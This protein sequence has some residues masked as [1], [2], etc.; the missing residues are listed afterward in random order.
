MAVEKIN[1]MDMDLGVATICLKTTLTLY[2]IGYLITGGF[3]HILTLGVVSIA[4]ITCLL[5]VIRVPRPPNSAVEKIIGPDPFIT[6]HDDVITT[7]AHRGAGLDAPENSLEAFRQCHTKGVD[8]IEFDV[9]LTA[10][11][12]PIVFHDDSLERMTGIHELVR[13]KTYKE[14]EMLDISVHHPYKEDFPNTKIPTLDETIECLLENNQK[15]FIDIKDNNPHIVDVILSAYERCPILYEKAITTSFFPNIIY[16]IR[17]RNPKI[18]CSLAWRPHSFTSASYSY[19][20]GLGERMHSSFHMH[21]I[22]CLLDWLHETLF[23][24]VTH[25]ILGLSF[26]L[27]HKD[28]ISGKNCE[29]LN[30]LGIIY[31]YKINRTFRNSC[32][33]YFF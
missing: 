31:T 1:I 17:K 14:L 5:Y 12:V 28:A 2:T 22:Y 19:T 24:T 11:Y 20:Q 29:D 25:Y 33:F 10:D 6:E 8:F 30:S 9:T 23:M 7:I 4:V 32:A 13:D 26:V 16:M 15:M 27:L 18:V 3:T 21:I